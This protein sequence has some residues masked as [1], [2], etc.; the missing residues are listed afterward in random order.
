MHSSP[1]LS[2][3]TQSRENGLMQATRQSTQK[4]SRGMQG[5]SAC[6]FLIINEL[7]NTG[8]AMIERL[9]AF[10]IF[11][12]LFLNR[13]GM[14]IYVDTWHAAKRKT[15][16]RKWHRTQGKTSNVKEFL[17]LSRKG[18]KKKKEQRRGIQCIFLGLPMSIRP[19]P[20]KI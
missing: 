6:L 11:S 3:L 2:P 20:G 17:A 13:A 4:I 1:S 9:R 8:H 10:G 7:F 15:S 19:P 16:Q 18:R 5:H 14:G 12:A